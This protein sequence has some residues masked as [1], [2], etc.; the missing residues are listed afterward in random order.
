M[1]LV[2]DDR[3]IDHHKTILRCSTEFVNSL[4]YL[5]LIIPSLRLIPRQEVN[6]MVV[7]AQHQASTVWRL[8]CRTCFC[9]FCGH[10]EEVLVQSR[11]HNEGKV[12]K[13]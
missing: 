12:M 3:S 8:E 9:A 11:Y 6:K 7:D 10:P 4:I 13:S 2:G 1:F 5:K